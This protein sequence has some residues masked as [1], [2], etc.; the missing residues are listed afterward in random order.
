MCSIKKKRYLYLIPIGI[1]VLMLL[2]ELAV[3]RGFGLNWNDNKFLI[4]RVFKD[5][6]FSFILMIM[7]GVFYE[8]IQVIRS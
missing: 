7:F 1:I 6:S 2:I 3:V 8:W 5:F 4:L